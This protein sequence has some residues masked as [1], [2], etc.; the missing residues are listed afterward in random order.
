MGRLDD[1]ANVSMMEKVSSVQHQAATP[2]SEA[3][4]CIVNGL[5]NEAARLLKESERKQLEARALSREASDN[6]EEVKRILAKVN[7]LLLKL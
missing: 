6:H 2:E 1:E 3:V 4:V 7:A 5:L